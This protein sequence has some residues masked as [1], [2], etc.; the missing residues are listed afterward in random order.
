MFK[1]NRPY[2]PHKIAEERVP[3]ERHTNAAES[4]SKLLFQ[5]DKGLVLLP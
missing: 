1:I 3:E 5:L 2:I 4:L